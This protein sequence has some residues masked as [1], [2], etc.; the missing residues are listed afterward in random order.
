L[1]L[2]ARRSSAGA[3]NKWLCSGAARLSAFSK[4]VALI[5]FVIGLGLT[6]FVFKKVPQGF[7]PTE[8]FRGI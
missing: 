5:L 2:Q 1:V 8:E 3:I 4:V 7:V 6:Y